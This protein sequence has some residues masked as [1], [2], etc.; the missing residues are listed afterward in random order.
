MGG[1]EGGRGE[2]ELVLF[3]E[4]LNSNAFSKENECGNETKWSA[5]K[6][7]SFLFGWENQNLF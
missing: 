5:K 1:R 4:R 2:G 3:V 6:M 7:I